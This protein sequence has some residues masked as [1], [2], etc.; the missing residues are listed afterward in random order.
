LTLV[1]SSTTK[2]VML[3]FPAILQAPGWLQSATQR[4][5]RWGPVGVV[6]ENSREIERYWES[7]RPSR[8]SDGGGE[9]FI[10]RGGGGYRR[11]ARRRAVARSREEKRKMIASSADGWVPPIGDVTKRYALWAP[12]DWL[13]GHA[14]GFR[15]TGRSLFLFHFFFHFLFSVLNSLTNIWIYFCRFRFWEFFRI[16]SR[17]VLIKVHCSRIIFMCICI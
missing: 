3:S 15:S 12:V 2:R 11:G 4:G 10:G 17:M 16:L 13:M 7:W 8:V 5:L 6:G 9:R 14:G 1:F